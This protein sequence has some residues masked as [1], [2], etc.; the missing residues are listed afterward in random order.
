MGN[1]NEEARMSEL[2]E[3]FL[4]ETSG[5]DSFPVAVFSTLA[6]AEAWVAAANAQS[7]VNTGVAGLS[8]QSTEE[9][10]QNY[11]VSKQKLPLDQEH[12]GPQ[13]AEEQFIGYYGS[14]ERYDEWMSGG[15]YY[16][17]LTP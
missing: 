8:C 14:H 5:Y 13:T 4:V 6:Q 7:V 12:P 10:A 2:T 15:R 9:A 16:K 3:V 1:Q 17:D 11:V